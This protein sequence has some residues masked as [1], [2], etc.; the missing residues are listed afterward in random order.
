MHIDTIWPRLQKANGKD[1]TEWHDVENPEKVENLILEALQKHFSQATDT[2][3]T[4]KIW[5]D[6]L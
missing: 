1:I 6:R 3:I 4:N 5:R 2:L